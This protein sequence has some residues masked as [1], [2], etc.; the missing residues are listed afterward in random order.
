MSLSGASSLR[1]SPPLLPAQ[2]CLSLS[3]H[4]DSGQE[5]EGFLLSPPPP[6]HGGDRLEFTEGHLHFK[7][8][9]ELSAMAGRGLDPGTGKGQKLVNSHSLCF[10]GQRCAQ[11]DS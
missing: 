5:P 3:D 6:K 2:T 10:T 7:R 9:G 8:W 11:M 4:A 1:L